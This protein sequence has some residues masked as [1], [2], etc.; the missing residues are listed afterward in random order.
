MKETTASRLQ[1]ED[2]LDREP[3]I[4]IIGDVHGHAGELRQVLA[5]LGYREAGP[6][7]AFRHPRRRAIF[8]GDLIDRGP[9]IAATLSLV[10]RMVLDGSA[11]CV[12]GNHEWNAL[13]W[14]VRRPGEKAPLRAHTHGHWR[15]HGETLKQLSPGMYGEA[16]D[17]YRTLP[18]A[19]HADGCYVVHA[20]WDP[21]AQ[22]ELEAARQRH[23]GLTDDF[24][25]E[26]HTEGTRLHAA[27][28]TTL[29]GPEMELPEGGTFL[30]KEGFARDRVR[31]RWF[32]PPAGRTVRSWSLP[33]AE[34]LPE[35]PLPAGCERILAPWP[36]QAPPIFFGHYWMQGPVPV[37]LRDNVAC[38][39]WSVAAG[40]PLVAYRFQG[41]PTL[42]C[43]N[44]RAVH[45]TERGF[46]H[47]EWMTG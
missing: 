10:S 23:G 43:R 6:R 30:D 38:L 21:R 34:G 7:G 27:V 4:D 14:N 36:V 22:A 41:E 3:G 42:D 8:V 5:A 28:E 17:W 9:E 15:Q 19:I 40:G 29:K 45:R 31:V 11:S 46:E 20:C 39:D 24:L 1:Q 18:F 13:G 16:L 25:V 26:A 2:P 37:P 47:L 12:L 44:L 32:D 35:V 33:E